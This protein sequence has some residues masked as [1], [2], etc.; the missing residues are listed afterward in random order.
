L[1]I[2]V[3]EAT[4][5]T[6]QAE[7]VPEA[8]PV[9][10][11]D[12]LMAVPLPAWKRTFDIFGAGL[13]LIVFSPVMLV[14]AVLIKLTSKGPIIFRQQRAGLG[15]R[16][17]PF[18]KFRSMVADAE[19]QKAELVWFNEQTGPIFKMKRD[20]RVTMVGRF[21]RKLSL[22][23]LPQL[24]NV[25]QGEMSLVGPRP[26]TLD[27]VPYYS[28]WQR[29]RLEMTPGLTCFWQISGRSHVG[30]NEWVRMD[31]RYATER[32]FLTDLKILLMTVPAV[33]SCRGA[34]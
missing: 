33:V 14:V 19:G 3:G 1:S 24:W 26:P 20:P 31:I 18:L 21:I 27:E 13:G 5:E 2:E 28:K 29:R 17:F 12:P 25:L 11:M 16:P 4:W 23:E 7:W 8:R 6:G 9:M 10:P 32:S 30:F 34:H 15:G 22:D